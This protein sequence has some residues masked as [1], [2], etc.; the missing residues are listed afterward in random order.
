VDTINDARIYVVLPVHNRLNTTKYFI[1]HLIAQTYKNYELILVDDACTDGTSEYVKRKIRKL[2]V[3]PGNGKL[4]WAGSLTKAYWYLFKYKAKDDDIVLIINDDC[5]FDRDYFQR[6]INDPELTFEAV[7]ISPGHSIHT[8]FIERGF[9]IE[10]KSLKFDKLREAQEPDALTTR[11]LYMYYSTYKSLGP[12][13]QWLL[14]HYLSDLDYTIRAKRKGFKLVVSYNS[15]LYI[16]RSNTGSHNDDSKSLKDL[17]YNH[18][19]SKKTAYSTLYWGNFVILACPWKYKLKSFLQVYKAFCHKLRRLL[20]GKTVRCRLTS[21]SLRGKG[22]L[23]L[24]NKLK[25]KGPDLYVFHHIPKCGGTSA[26]EALSRWFTCV[27]DYKKEATIEEFRNS[28]INIKELTPEKILCGHFEYEGCYLHQRYPEVFS[29]PRFKLISFV[30]D[31]LYLQISLY[32]YEKKIGKRPNT[33][34]EECIL[35]RQNYMSSIFCCDEMNYKRVLDRY[36][37]FG[38]AEE[39]QMSFDNLADKLGKPRILVPLLNTT[40]RDNQHL[41]DDILEKFRE[42]NRLDYLIYEYCRAKLV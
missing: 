2:T 41:S 34:L 8:D 5:I 35:L 14:P 17:L 1:E 40:E 26:R 19:V 4:W 39:L 28:R 22:W 36:F 7:I 37:F 10:W 32:Y 24:F 25:K 13:H 30:R 21:C 15:F 42:R 11:G 20:W 31:P 33:L 16:D 18:F 12:M 9:A 6:I 29:D 3:L 38:I 23:F 27:P